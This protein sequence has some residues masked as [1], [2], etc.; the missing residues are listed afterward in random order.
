MSWYLYTNDPSQ[1][2]T[3]AATATSGAIGANTSPTAAMK[4]KFEL[5][6]RALALCREIERRRS[7][8]SRLHKGTLEV[9]SIHE[10]REVCAP[11]RCTSLSVQA[12]ERVVK[13]LL[14]LERDPDKVDDLCQVE[15]YKETTEPAADYETAYSEESYKATDGKYVNQYDAWLM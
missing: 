15:D 3:Q 4:S 9:V 10:C 8:T 14:G 1:K 6:I 12:G 2:T 7:L 13:R 11:R 5:R